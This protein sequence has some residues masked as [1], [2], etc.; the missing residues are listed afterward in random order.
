[1][2][3]L[4]KNQQINTYIKLLHIYTYI[5]TYHLFFILVLIF[6][7]QF[8][9]IHVLVKKVAMKKTS[10]KMKHKTARKVISYA[11]HYLT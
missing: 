10:D 7:Y 1:M 3:I 11:R 8:T 5:H 2:H 9:H 4:K 6:V